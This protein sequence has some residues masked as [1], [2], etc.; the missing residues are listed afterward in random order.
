MSTLEKLIQKF[1]PNGVE[2]K[3][4]WC[5]TAWDKRFN[6]V[7]RAKQP[8]VITYHYFLANELTALAVANGTVK[9]LTTNSSNIFTTEAL[10]GNKI[11]KGEIVA[12]P[13]GGNPNIQYYKGKFL[14]ADNRIA[15]SLDTGILDTKFLYYVLL[16]RTEEIGSYYRGS[17]IKHP[18][19]SKVLAMKIPIP[20]IPVQKE[21]V[22]MLDDMAGL[23]DAL[24]E[25]L[26]VRKKQYEWCR[27]RLQKI[28]AVHGKVYIG[29]VILSLNTGLNPR[30]FFK[31]NTADATNYYVTIREMH[32][33][34][35]EFTDSTDRINDDALKLCNHRSNLEIG[36]L[37]FSGTGTIGEMV[38]IENEPRNWN[39]KEGV[40][41]IKPRVDMLDAHY[42]RF[43]L[44]MPKIRKAYLSKTAGGT[45]K[46]IPMAQMKRIEIPLPSLQ[47][48][49]EIVKTFDSFEKLCNSM[50]E[51]LPG[52]IA[53]R[54]QQYE[55]YRDK[56]LAFKRAG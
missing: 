23:I 27:E 15:T 36:D 48:Q 50:T 54:K 55:Y 47:E 20:P 37:L 39:I 34:S 56:L 13:W 24:E 29:D 2:Y 28:V 43:I 35:I 12:L 18:D 51:G 14:T 22:R 53:L 17:G 31:L 25:E 4:L 40:Y 33:G 32:D 30:K 46:S 26:A 42:L 44:M 16:S 1:C 5:L 6:S 7:D 10:A 49:I 41:A 9:L 8:T 3:P 45:V 21:I 11:S 38:V 19:M 52:E